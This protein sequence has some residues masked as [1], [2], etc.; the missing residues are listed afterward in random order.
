MKEARHERLHTVGFHFYEMSRIGKSIET[1][2]RLLVA[3][4]W[5]EIEM[6]LTANRYGFLLEIMKLFWN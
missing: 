4:G 3:R 6:V 5:G 2:S 1:E